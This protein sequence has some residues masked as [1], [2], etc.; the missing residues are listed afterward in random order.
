MKCFIRR[1][2]D[3]LT[4]FDVLKVLLSDGIIALGYSNDNGKAFVFSLNK[5]DIISDNSIIKV[6]VR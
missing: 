2:S 1:N 6:I 5:E 3:W 4:Q